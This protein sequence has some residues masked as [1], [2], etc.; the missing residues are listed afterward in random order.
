MLN[1]VISIVF[2][3]P[4]HAPMVLYPPKEDICLLIN[5]KAIHVLVA[6]LN[7]WILSPVFLSTTNATISAFIN[8]ALVK[9]YVHTVEYCGTSMQ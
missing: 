5:T 1:T 7:T 2:C 3:S 8:K 4:S 9:W 6:V